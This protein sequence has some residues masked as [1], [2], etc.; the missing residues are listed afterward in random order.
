MAQSLTR[1]ELCP[2]RLVIYVFW[3]TF[4]ELWLLPAGGLDPCVASRMVMMRLFL[5]EIYLYPYWIVGSYSTTVYLVSMVFLF[6]IA[7]LYA[8]QKK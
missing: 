4:Y 3:Y 6:W 1:L 7:I 2:K 5:L 8:D